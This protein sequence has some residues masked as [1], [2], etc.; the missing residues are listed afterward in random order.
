MLRITTILDP[1]ITLYVCTKCRFNL[2]IGHKKCDMLTITKHLRVHVFGDLEFL[3]SPTTL[4][5]PDQEP[6][7]SDILQIQEVNFRCVKL[8]L[9]SIIKPV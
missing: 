5:T 4:Q 1:P 9:S 8:T 3:K 2:D 7:D 6:L